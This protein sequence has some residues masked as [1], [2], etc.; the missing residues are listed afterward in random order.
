LL[1]HRTRSFVPVEHETKEGRSF[2][3]GATL[4]TDGA[5]FSVYS[6]HA[7]G[8]EL[9]LFDCVDDTRPRRVIWIDPLT[10]RTYHYWHIFVPGVKAGQIYSYRVNGA[11]DPPSGLRFDPA[12]V[13]VDPYGRGAVVPKNYSRDA[14]RKKGDNTASAIKSVVTD[15]RPYDWEGDTPLCRPSSQ[16]IVYEMHVRGFT[17]HPSSGVAEEKRGTFAGLIEK[18]PYLKKLG[19]TAVELMPVFQF[20]PQDSPTG[21]VNY[22]GYAPVSFFAPHQA[23]SSRQDPLGP[24]DEF[25]DMV[26][27]LHRAGIEIILDVVFN[28]TTEGNQDGPTLSFRGLDNSTYYIL[29]QDRSRYANYSG[30]G[31]TLN[32]NHPVVRRMILDSLRYWVEEMHVDGF[33]FDLAAI[34]ER[35]ES[36]QLMP[37]PPVLWDI[38]SDPELAGT[39]LIAEAWDAAGL[40]EVGSFIGDSWKEWNGRFRDDVRSFFRGDQGYIGRFADRLLGSPAIYSHKEREVEQSVNFVT[41]H[42]GFTLNDLVSYNQKHNE[43]NG[44]DNRDGANDNRSWNCGVEG[45]SDDP[46]VEKLR[47]RQVKN[48]LTVTMFSAGMPMMLM[49]DEVRRTQLGNNNA[50]CQDNETSWFDWALLAKHA[51]VHRFVTLLNARRVLRDPEPERQRVSLN[52]LLR[53]A[54]LAWHGVKLGQP[55]WGET[56]HSIAFTVEI[57]REKLL[58]HVILNAYWQPLDFELPRLDGAG[59]NLWRRWIDTAL[60]S[61]HDILEWE[62]AEPIA[63]NVYRAESRSV[64]IIVGGI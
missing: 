43:P 44:E 34:L 2:P 10:N 59:K 17:R 54:N 40:Y 13:L 31:N 14:A 58:F 41:C 51:D 64:V 15:T 18:V 22:W 4:S 42:D 30:T 35:D 33:R 46:G 21:G 53:G 28:H 60:D 61:P 32:T 23:Y 39:K 9:L 37:N 57:R 25:R 11:F 47:N 50:Y 48:F 45:P 8:M 38:E 26:K 19:V 55:D 24:L 16:T 56:S 63:G 36:G 1:N 7:T 52:Q 12:K 49:G 3:L 6:K 27:A 29:E 5:N 62:A 20:D